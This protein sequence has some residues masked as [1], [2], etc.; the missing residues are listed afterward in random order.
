MVSRSRFALLLGAACPILLGCG[1]GGDKPAAE[2]PKVEAPSPFQTAELPKGVPP[3]ASPRTKPEPPQPAVRC[4]RFRDLHQEAKLEHVYVNGEKG[5]CLLMET[6]GG[7]AGWLDYDGDGH[8]DLYLNQGGDPTR[9]ADAKQP[10]DRLFR[11]RGDGTFEDVTDAARIIEYR[12]SQ[13]VAVGDYD[14]D[15]FDDVYITSINGNT[16]FRNQG[17]GTFLD[18]T[19]AA[20]VR[21]GRWGA[22][23]AWADLDLDGNLDLYVCNYCL[24]DPLHP[25]PCPDKKGVLHICHP[26]N[27]PPLVDE[28]Y[29]NRGDGVFAPE[30]KKRG[31]I[32]E[33]GRGLGVAVA[34]LNNDGLP[35]VFVTNDT[36]ANF[37]F[38]N[39]GKGTFQENAMVLGCAADVNGNF[40]A[41]MGVAVCDFFRSGHFDLYVTHFTDESDTL[42][43]NYG[44]GGFQDES[45]MVGLPNF[46]TDHLSF[47]VVAADFN[48]D[49]QLE[50]FA[51][52]G[53]I[54]NSPGF[55]HYRM[56]PLLFAFDGKR[57]HDCS[58]QGGPFFEG[59]RVGRAVAACDYDDDG[60]LEMLVAHENSPAALLKVEPPCGHWLKFFF[61]GRQSNRR[62]INCRITLKVGPNTYLQELCGGTSYSATHQPTLIY[63]LGDWT[64]PCTATVRW[65]SGLV[66]TIENLAVDRTVLL[67]ES[68]ASRR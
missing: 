29:M 39:Q 68:N 27:V 14:N 51:T 40:M 21:D 17:D 67:D 38:I 36:T 31:L 57:F 56:K 2:P 4:P 5:K 19:E 43:R 25:I 3:D 59:K 60:R 15:G 41:N 44:E 63:G 7:G 26:G 64:Q 66:Q 22:S 11:N 16:L 55:P 6:T 32:D 46:T 34:D 10:N 28:C 9:P 53:H 33:G 58:A 12:Y 54:E 45:A 37:L 13:G 35:D 48:Q 1:H 61:R 62:G 52:S 18:V 8:W 50:V 24:F 65:P 30:A 42:F 49:G 47:G 20:G 23:A